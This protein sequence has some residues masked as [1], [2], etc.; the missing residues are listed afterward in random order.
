MLAFLSLAFGTLI[1]ED[2][3]C[4]SAGLLVQRGAID[5]FS[6]IFGCA[7]GILVGDVGLWAVGRIF[8]QGAL[9]WPWVARHLE[10]GEVDRLGTWLEKHAASA[11]LGSR[12]LPGARLPL[13]VVAGVVRMPCAA[14]TLWASVAALLWTLFLVLA[15]VTLVD[16]VVARFSGAIGVTWLPSSSRR[17]RVHRC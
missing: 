14:F 2:L 8:G 9:T 10:Q 3:T 5:P 6:A 11:I 1:S 12:F 4:I 17:V 16:A 15:T 7:A 13:Y